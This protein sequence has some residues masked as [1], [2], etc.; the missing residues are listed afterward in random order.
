MKTSRLA[1]LVIGSLFLASCTDPVA[2]T[3]A[4]TTEEETPTDKPGGPEDPEDPDV[5][6]TVEWAYE[7]WDDL[8]NDLSQ[9]VT[10]TALWSRTGGTAE[11]AA[12]TPQ[13]IA[14][15]KYVRLKAGS[16]LHGESVREHP[17]LKVVLNDGTVMILEAEG[18]QSWNR[19]FYG[20]FSEEEVTQDENVGGRTVSHTFFTRIYRITDA[21]VR[22]WAEGQVPPPTDGILPDGANVYG[23][24]SCDGVGIPDVVVHDGYAFTKTDGN[25]VYHLHSDKLLGYVSI[26]LP[27][28]YEPQQKGFL[29]VIHQ[30]LTQKVF[31]P[32][33]KDF[34]LVRAEGD[35]F[36]LIVMGD[37]HLARR[38]NDRE[39]FR[40]FTADVR[41][42]LAAHPGWKVYGLTL[43]DMTWDY[44]WYSKS[45]Y[46][47]EYL[48][49]M[50]DP[51]EGVDGLMTFHT[52]GNHD[53]DMQEAGDFLTEVK[54]VRDI[55]PTY[56]S[57]NL[58]KVHFIVLD[59]ILCTN[60]G[61]GNR[62]YSSGLDEDQMH[63]LRQDLSFVDR[64]TPLVISM[65]AP[66]FYDSADNGRV[67][68]ILQT[69]YKSLLSLA[70]GYTATHILTGHTHRILNTD[71]REEANY[72]EHNAGAVC[73]TW[74][75]SQKLT[76]INIG[77]DGA[78]G[79]Y[80]LWDIDGTSFSWRFIG[81][82]EDPSFQFR[83]FDLNSIEISDATAASW[84]PEGSAWARKHLVA[85]YGS[86]FPKR[87][88]NKV[89]LNVW[90]Y[91]PG[92]TIKVV[93]KIGLV[94][95]ELAVTQVKTYDPLHI[96][97]LSIPRL[98]DDISEE[99]NF[100]TDLSTHFFEVTAS[101]PST[102]L[103]ITVTDE[104]GNVSTETMTRPK[105][106]TLDT[107]R[108]GYENSY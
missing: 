74:W 67:E 48:E 60:D 25:G 14:P 55:A 94:S 61:K 90:N 39:E 85:L 105:A 54:Y 92:W 32:E 41:D 28:G 1:L 79:G 72:F 44:Y 93:E 37:M 53:H 23:V 73:A 47:P 56:Y 8:Y 3:P 29:P 18:E 65:H 42:I 63:W 84:L 46:F 49:D 99:P 9:A 15:G 104:F 89:L 100:L 58:G 7:G 27:S 21:I 51:E 91:N 31:F 98:N 24:V 43:G 66:V 52:I 36:R 2:E 5:D 19:S 11:D 107:Y 102:T 17:Y 64:E 76:R 83:S 106:F 59:N 87:S 57:F 13:K 68:S 10:V 101:G 86:R 26:S 22:D 40:K 108:S 4:V 70:S 6:V 82:K 75:W 34:S 20:G 80:A 71:K 62:S 30:P 96:L 50:N 77:T 12:A 38:N 103:E 45:Y 95:Q 88:D 78:P 35:H 81:T 97:A 16:F 33:R 69:Q